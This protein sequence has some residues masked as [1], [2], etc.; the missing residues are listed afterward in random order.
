MSYET[1]HLWPDGCK[2][3]D[4]EP[5]ER[6]QLWHYACRKNKTASPRPAVIVCPGGG[7]GKKADHE[8]GPLA[9]LFA[10]HGMDGF[11]LRYRHAPQPFPA[12]YA[13]AARA[14]RYVRANAKRLGIDPNRIALMGFSAGGHLASTVSIQPTLHIDEEDDLADSVSAR[15]DRMI[16]GYPVVSFLW[17]NHA[18][19]MKNL[20][21]EDVPRS[22]RFQFSNEMHITT[23]SPPAFLFHT[24]EDPGVPCSNSLR[25]ALAYSQAGVP[26][27]IHQFEKGRHGVG[28]AL[29]DPKL[30]VWTELLVNWLSG[31]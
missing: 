19:S 1:I 3:N 29:D 13:D 17:D 11:V 26:C 10:D 31:W 25:I 6:P 28:M 23:D 30:K 16:L 27:E 4:S 5:N 9:E 22:V 15:P 2:H 18:G 8:G 12:P 24:A 7:Y 20:L 14:I 21:G